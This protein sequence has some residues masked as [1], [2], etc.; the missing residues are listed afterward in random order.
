MAVVIELL[1]ANDYMIDTWRQLFERPIFMNIKRI[2]HAAASGGPR[3]NA[4]AISLMRIGRC[5]AIITLIATSVVIVVSN[6]EWCR[7]RVVGFV[8]L[9][10]LWLPSFVKYL[11]RRRPGWRPHAFSRG[12]KKKGKPLALQPRIGL[13]YFSENH[14]S[15]V[16]KN[17]NNSNLQF[18]F[19]RS[20][21]ASC[22]RSGQSLKR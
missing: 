6:E 11:R 13:S 2:N 5:A 18:A 9:L 17:K 12:R 19:I 3:S 4:D 14:G 15:D 20:H 21:R 8:L 16:T 22:S 7:A 10:L 1:A